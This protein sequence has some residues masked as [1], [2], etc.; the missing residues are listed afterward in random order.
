MDIRATF[1]KEAVDK[2]YHMLEVN[3]VYTFSG[4]RIK[5][6]NMQYN[7]CKS[8]NELSFD[9]NAE[10][11]LVGNDTSIE[12][13]HLDVTKIAQLEAIEPNAYVDILGVVKSVTPVSTIMSKKTQ[14]ELFKSELVVVDDSGAGVNVT[15]WGDR[16]K[17]AQNEFANQPLVGFK[18]LRVSDYG[19]RSLSVSGGPV[20]IEPTIPEGNVIRHWWNTQ[21][22]HDGSNIRSMSSSGSG[23]MGGRE[24]TF[25]ERMPISSIQNEQMGFSE[26]PDYLSF[27]ASINFIKRDK[28]GGPWYTACSNPEPPCKN[29]C[30]VTA[31]ADGGSWYCDRCQQTR[32]DCTRRYIFSATVIDD[33]CTSWVS[34]FNDQALQLLGEENTADRVNEMYFEQ[35]DPDNGFES[36]FQKVLFSDWIFKCKVKQETVGDESRIKASI[37][38][39]SPVDYA[40]ESKNLL[41]AIAKMG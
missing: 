40:K 29:M 41:A 22:V 6:A 28:D 19:G 4:G 1:F 26:K 16:A 2:F 20:I 23:G 35:A 3:Q 5:A 8:G 21:G 30:K 13:Q 15:I 34:V 18:R 39:M 10:I 36:M 12:Q 27:K 7:T 14:K 25:E 32:P 17:T 9:Q 37:V 24:A 31:T 38:S 11:H 33:T